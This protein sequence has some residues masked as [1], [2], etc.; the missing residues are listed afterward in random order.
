M[1]ELRHDLN[2]DS[3]SVRELGSDFETSHHTWHIIR[4][5]NPDFI[6]PITFRAY[7]QCPDAFTV[8]PSEGYVRPGE[9]VYVTLGVTMKGCMMNEAFE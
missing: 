5:T 7:I 2:N 8:Y 6:R 1:D 9:T 4:L 3:S